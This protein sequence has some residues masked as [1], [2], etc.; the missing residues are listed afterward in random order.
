MRVA[1]VVPAYLPAADFGGPV[2]KMG[3]LAR[4]LRQA[5]V[6]VDIW[7]ADFGQGRTRLPPGTRDVD[8]VP[9]TYLKRLVAY[10]WSPVV[11]RA[12][13]HA[14][15][16]PIEL[17]HLFGYR[18][19]LTLVVAAALRRRGIPLVAEPEGMTIG[20]ARNLFAKQVVD[21]AV[22]HRYLRSASV[23]I[24]TSELEADE[25]R[26]IVPRERVVVRA[27]PVPVLDRSGARREGRA[28]TLSLAFVGRIAPLKNLEV[29]V[30]AVALVH[31]VSLDII[32]PVDVPQIEALVRGQID[33]L[34]ISDRVTMPGPLYGDD[35]AE[36]LRG[37]DAFVL[38]SQYENFGIA[39]VEASLDGMP[40]IISTG[41]G[42]AALLDKHRA[43]L[44]FD[45]TSV[46]ELADKITL[47]RD[48][49]DLRHQ[50]AAASTAVAADVDP[51]RIASDQLE[52]YRD[53]LRGSRRTL[54]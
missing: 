31:R 44:V 51:A 53:V 2:A 39:A 36:R 50:L 37:A 23:V 46:Q 54:Q 30:R 22:G 9:V 41:A 7:T 18:D 19:G 17:A 45:P 13:R 29:L 20:R 21:R 35:L 15:K 26:S 8:G 47:L 27:N 43:A 38:P 28:G 24:A 12:W 4:E 1:L 52:I 3:Q 34:G 11:P 33:Q 10:R 42:A 48:S 49:M 5:G 32:G 25:L 40:V 6:E 14:S 16:S